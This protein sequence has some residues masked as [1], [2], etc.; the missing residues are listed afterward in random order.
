MIVHE[1]PPELSPSLIDHSSKPSHWIGI[2]V[3]SLIIFVVPVVGA[4]ALNAT[5]IKQN[6]QLISPVAS[7]DQEYI[8]AIQTSANTEQTPG[9]QVEYELSLAERFLAKAIEL[10]N[11]QTEQTSKDK[12]QIVFLLN[13]ALES[14]NRAVSL[15]A[16]DART[17]TSRGRIYQAISMV[18]PEMKELADLDFQKAI[19]LGST[20][21]TLAPQTEDPVNLLPTKQATE[22]NGQKAMIA[23]PEEKIT[24]AVD[25]SEDQN[26]T[27]GTVTLGAGQSEVFVSYPSVSNTTQ[28]YINSEENPDN[29]T[30]YV[31]NKEEGKGFTIGA[32]SAPSNALSI[33]WWEVK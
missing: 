25:G 2:G 24:T 26:A 12:E 33:T 23:G 21:P 14:A 7:V 27:K 17:Y 13:Q 3:A 16:Q 31:K 1:A 18:K 10:S 8:P 30:L 11:T 22:T 29:V 20:N 4:L 9:T 32:T 19:A 15:N 28:L 5:T 6:Q